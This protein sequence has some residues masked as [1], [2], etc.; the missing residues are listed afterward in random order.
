MKEQM[1]TR[2]PAPEI[3]DAAVPA[4]ANPDADAIRR[5]QSDPEAFVTIFDRHFEPIHRYL[6]RRV[7]RDLADELASETFAQA[8]RR[9]STFEPLS[10]SALP[11]LYGIAANLVRRHRRTETRRLRAYARTGVDESVE[12]DVP[13]VVDRVDAGTLAASLAAALASLSA[14]DRETV[15]LIAFAELTYG[16]VGLALGIPSGTVGSRMNRI[17]SRL[18]AHLPSDLRALR[19]E[20]S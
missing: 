16:E 7:G 14:D 5:S 10:E 9:R 13:G 15:S 2:S 4:A 18:A 6:H 12:L 3:A 20:T 11:W 19:E 17:R 8:Y 1:G